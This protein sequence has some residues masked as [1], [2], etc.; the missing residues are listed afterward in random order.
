LG[1]LLNV[2]SLLYPPIGLKSFNSGARDNIRNL[3]YVFIATTII[4][5][6]TTVYFAKRKPR[7]EL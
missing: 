7:I 1:K 5:I 2:N 4:L 6:A 3:L